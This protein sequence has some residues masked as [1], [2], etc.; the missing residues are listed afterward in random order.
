MAEETK[1]LDAVEEEDTKT[2]GLTDDTGGQEE[3][4]SP[5]SESGLSEEFVSQWDRALSD[6]REAASVAKSKPTA[7]NAK[8]VKSREEEAAERLEKMI[9]AED[10]DDEPSRAL[11]E[12]AKQHLESARR[13]TETEKRYQQ[14][15]ESQNQKIE[16]L[17]ESMYR[18][19]FE[20]K[21]PELAG[22]YE[23]L[24]KEAS[25]DPKV[26]S[27]YRVARNSTDP[28]AQDLFR[29]YFADK[30]DQVVQKAAEAKKG[31]DKNAAKNGSSGKAK[32]AEGTKVM[33][34]R[35]GQAQAPESGGKSLYERLWPKMAAKK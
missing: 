20:A 22:E 2:E 31:G 6:L 10:L 18:S 15:I 33:G 29:M 7:E 25:N 5:K 17:S 19:Q 23:K 28:S 32:S 14:L 12:I 26:L 30:W 3:D 24:V 35:A 13:F 8:A 27:A 11:R 4:G 21:H 16:S 9:E 34:S 1:E